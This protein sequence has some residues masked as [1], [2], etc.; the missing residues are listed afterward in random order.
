MLDDRESYNNGGVNVVRLTQL[1][2]ARTPLQDTSM[3]S[4]QRLL[5]AAEKETLLVC[6]RGT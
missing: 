1:R 5:W 4:H 6:L 2:V 3:A